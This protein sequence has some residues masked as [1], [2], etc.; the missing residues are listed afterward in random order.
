MSRRGL[1]PTAPVDPAGRRTER[2]R[3]RSKQAGRE[4]HH[5]RKKQGRPL[6]QRPQRRVAGKTQQIQADQPIYGS[7]DIY[8]PSQD[9][10]RL[11][12]WVGTIRANGESARLVLS[13]V[14]VRNVTDL[15]AVLWFC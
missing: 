1:G 4:I 5:G 13:R 10:T 8:V 11:C 7:T 9:F 15:R 2:S 3:L 12:R 14:S 6:N